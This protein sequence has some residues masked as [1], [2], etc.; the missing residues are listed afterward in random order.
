M[1]TARCYIFIAQLIIYILKFLSHHINGIRLSEHVIKVKFYFI[2]EKFQ[3]LCRSS[4]EVEYY[5]KPLKKK[6]WKEKE[7]QDV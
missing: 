3:I 1:T 5:A 2:E 6:N 4:L 7:D